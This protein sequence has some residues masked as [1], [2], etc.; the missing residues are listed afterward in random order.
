MSFNGETVWKFQ[1]KKKSKIPVLAWRKK[2]RN[3]K[4][5]KAKTEHE[6][7]SKE[8]INWSQIEK[9]IQIQTVGTLQ[10]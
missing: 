10:G 8:E 4:T 9:S 5:P 6:Q 7:G 2:Q 3:Q 1:T